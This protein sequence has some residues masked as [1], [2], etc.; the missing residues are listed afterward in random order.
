MVQNKFAYRLI[1]V[2]LIPFIMAIAG[3]AATGPEKLAETVAPP[4]QKIAPSS[5]WWFARFR[6]HWPAEG[7][8]NWHLDLLIAHK[9]VAPALAQYK[10]AIFLW[11]FHRRAVRD[12]AGHQFSF[13]FYASAETA[14]Q[15]FNMLRSNEMLSEMKSAG[16]IIDDRYDNTDRISRPHIE[17][18]SDAS[19]PPAIQKNWPYFI[20]GASRMW[21]NLISDTIAGMPNL[22]RPLSIEENEQQYKKANAA[23]SELW[24]KKGQHAFLHHLS[25][26]FGYRAIIFYDK[27]MLKF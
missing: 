17:D 7:Q 10:D 9:I 24:Q 13:I 23:I 27:R 16:M 1:S 25:A 5:G 4:P 22:N 21:L 15:I 12:D 2:L 3:C 11:R 18:T 20:M 26:L 19:W 14:Y 8:V 6:M